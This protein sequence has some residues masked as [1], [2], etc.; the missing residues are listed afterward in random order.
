MKQNLKQNSTQVAISKP[1]APTP[2]AIDK[3]KFI[4]KT[5]KGWTNTNLRS[6]NERTSK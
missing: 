4:D 5:Y 6:G 3:A 2:E 1:K